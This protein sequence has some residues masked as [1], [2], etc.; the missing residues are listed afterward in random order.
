MVITAAGMSLEQAQVLSE[1]FSGRAGLVATP[2]PCNMAQLQ[3]YYSRSVKHSHAGSMNWSTKQVTTAH[4]ILLFAA[5]HDSNYGLT[6]TVN[7]ARFAGLKVLCG[8]YS[9][10]GS[11]RIPCCFRVWLA[12]KPE[13]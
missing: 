7:I 1:L 4:L 5:V 8:T 2:A 11:S 6:A 12:V 13:G 9:G 10:S 3:A